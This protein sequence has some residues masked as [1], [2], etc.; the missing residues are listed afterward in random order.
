MNDLEEQ[1]HYH[2]LHAAFFLFWN[3]MHS[4]SI[5]G[6]PPNENAKKEGAE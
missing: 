5:T 1:V 4:A 6:D 2:L 3:F